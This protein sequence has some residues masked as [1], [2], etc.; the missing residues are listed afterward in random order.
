MARN[1]RD[2]SSFD[3]DVVRAVDADEEVVE[4]VAVDIAR[5]IQRVAR[6]VSVAEISLKKL[7][8]S[9]WVV[10]AGRLTAALLADEVPIGVSQGHLAA[11]SEAASKDEVGLAGRVPRLVVPVGANQ[12][13]V[14][15]VAVDVT[16]SA[17]GGT[18]AVSSELTSEEVVRVGQGPLTVSPWARYWS[19]GDGDCTCRAVVYRV[20]G[21]GTAGPCGAL[22]EGRAIDSAAVQASTVVTRPLEVV[23]DLIAVD[24]HGGAADDAG[25]GTSGCSRGRGTHAQAGCVVG[26]VLGPAM[27]VSSPGVESLSG[28][29][30]PRCPSRSRPCTGVRRCRNTLRSAVRR[31]LSLGRCQDEVGQP[32]S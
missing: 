5:R 8:F 28:T 30:R 3:V 19:D 23:R 25:E 29:Q 27:P 1:Q 21:N 9:R 31:W 6:P 16:G 7:F 10:P 22:G 4:A 20:G 15:S 32:G 12:Q 11:R 2:L 24:V 13:V 26:G 14:A 17:D 18:R